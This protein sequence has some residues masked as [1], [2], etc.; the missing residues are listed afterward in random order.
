MHQAAG[1]AEI[2]GRAV[3]LADARDALDALDL[4]SVTAEQIG[5]RRH[6]YET[7]LEPLEHRSH[8]GQPRRVHAREW[9]R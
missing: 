9:T 6:S 4:R 7:A 1:A 8:G 3:E 5:Q 2:A